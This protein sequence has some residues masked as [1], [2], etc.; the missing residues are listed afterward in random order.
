MN[1][2]R[3]DYELQAEEDIN[4]LMGWVEA[5]NIDR[6]RDV[7]NMVAADDFA[8]T[9]M[10]WVIQRLAKL[11][12]DQEAHS[13]ELSVAM[14]VTRGLEPAGITKEAAARIA[15]ASDEKREKANYGR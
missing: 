12:V 13:Q 9:R 14:K 11:L 6:A 2:K 3:F 1:L 10:A 8:V 5:G 15:L 4:L 7:I